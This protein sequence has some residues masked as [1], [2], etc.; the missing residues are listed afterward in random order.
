MGEV[1]DLSHNIGSMS[2]YEKLARIQEEVMNTSF[3][4]SGE[5]KFQKYDYFELEDLLQKIIPLTIKYETTIMFSFTEHGVLKLKDWNPEK[6]EV[7]IRVPFPELEA[8][9]R[10]TNK[11]QSTGAYITY[12]KRYLLMNMFLIMEKDIVDS[13]TNNTG[14]KKETN[15]SKKEVDVDE[16]LNKIKAHIHKKDSTIP[17]TPVR[18]NLT[19]RNMLKKKEIDEVESKAVFEWFKKQEKE[20]KA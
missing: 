12:L 8:I 14:V 9:N 4:K 17:I 5:N 20:A 16:V 10:G 2:I 15:T 1:Q 18:I 19:R 7:S 6:G 13:N 11:I 3:S